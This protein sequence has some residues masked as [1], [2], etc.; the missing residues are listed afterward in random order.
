MVAV[1]TKVVP[2]ND[3]SS[4]IE[5]S[6][7][8]LPDSSE[9]FKSPEMLTEEFT[10][11]KTWTTE[12]QSLQTFHVAKESK[13]SD[14]N[15][16]Y[17]V[18]PYDNS[19]VKLKCVTLDGSDYINASYINF[20]SANDV[21]G[22]IACQAPLTNTFSHF[23]RMVWEQN[24]RVILMLTNLVEKNKEKAQKYWPN[25]GSQLQFGNIVVCGIT[26][27]TVGCVTL[28]TFK[29]YFFSA[30]GKLL[31]Q[32]D[33]YHIHY[34]DWTDMGTPSST[35]SIRQ[36]IKITEICSSK[37]KV[38]SPLLVH[39]S[40]GIGR[41]GTYIA[42]DEAIKRIQVK[43]NLKNPSRFIDVHHIVRELRKQRV[44]MVQTFDQYTFIYRAI[45]D[46]VLSTTNNNTITK[47]D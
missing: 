22:Y 11:L 33:L 26:T 37:S 14:K 27:K 3:K 2:L 38:K 12:F 24:I 8:I 16:Y 7:Q 31:E 28:K 46:Y 30:I 41:T 29:V 1:Q 25:D 40:A 15:R 19:R 36:L 17:D 6:L 5:P 32:R 42:I 20:K 45:Q 43:Q 39:C 4:I 35:Q 34:T 10:N 47:N 21:P 23:W 18:L 13:N 44:S 9:L